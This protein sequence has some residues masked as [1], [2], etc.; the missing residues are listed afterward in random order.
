MPI[1]NEQR[2]RKHQ[3]RVR[4]GWIEVH[5]HGKR[6]GPPNREGG[7]KAPHVSGILTREAECQ[8]QAKEPPECGTE[9]NG[10]TVWSGETV[11][12]YVR[13]E[14]ARQQDATVRQ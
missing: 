2:T 3:M 1:K 8:Q 7:E 5:V 14:S 4:P 10:Q 12:R 6:A 11:R 9:G 13:A